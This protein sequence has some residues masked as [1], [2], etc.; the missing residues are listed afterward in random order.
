M[1]GLSKRALLLALVFVVALGTSYFYFALLLPG[2]ARVGVANQMIGR[3]GFGGDF[4]P[5]WL[6]GRAVFQNRT[7]PYTPEMTREIQTGLFGRPMDPKRPYDPPVEFRAFSYPLYADL[8]AAPLL[9]LRFDAVRVILSV[10]LPVLTGA[11]LLWWL[12]AFGLQVSGTAAAI[13]IV[14]LL[15]SYPV[16]EGLYAQQAGLMC[17]IALAGSALLLARGRMFAAGALLACASVKPQLVWLGVLWLMVWAA[18][19]WV[20]RKNLIF[21]FGAA[22]SALLLASELL[23]PGWFFGWWRALTG[24]SH[25]TL[26]PLT[27]LVLGKYPGAAAGVATLALGMWMAWKVRRDP[28]DSERF[29]LATSFVLAVTVLL[30]PTGGAVYD[31]VILIP[32]VLWLACRKREVLAGKVGIRVIGIIAAGVLC[33][34]WVFACAVAMASIAASRWARTPAVL[35]FPTRMAAPLPFLILVL[36][37]FFVIRVL[38]GLGL[39]AELA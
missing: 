9:P 8:L 20:R 13:A 37:G 33:W 12:R 14:L 34:Q 32:A 6:T 26:P 25:Y 19:D 38:R 30:A 15:V 2:A 16:L 31:Q 21:G 28:A 4:Y 22:M 11:S 29:T 5:I 35:V 10:L 1:A 17:G 36:L 3:Y 27:Q 7:D 23:L 24:Y 18:S 39:R